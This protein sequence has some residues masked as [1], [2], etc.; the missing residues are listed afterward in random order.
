MKKKLLCVALS[1]VMTLSM[2][3]C[4]LFGVKNDA[5]MP[6]NTPS[7]ASSDDASKNDEAKA[8]EQAP[9]EEKKSFSNDGLILV[10]PYRYNMTTLYVF[11]DDGTLSDS[12]D[13]EPIS[14]QLKENENESYTYVTYCDGVFFFS[15]YKYE[16]GEN[17]KKLTAY[18][19]TTGEITDVI[20]WG[21]ENIYDV[22]VYE[23]KLTCSLS[24]SDYSS[25]TV[26]S[27]EKE[28][29]SLAFKETGTKYADI[30]DQI[31]TYNISNIERGCCIEHF[32]DKNGGLVAH[33]DDKYYLVKTDGS[34]E[35]IPHLTDNFYSLQGNADY[36][37]FTE[38]DDSY[39]TL[40][41]IC[42]DLSTGE[43]KKISDLS[44]TTMGFDNGVF[45]FAEKEDTEFGVFDLKIKSYNTAT[46]ELNTLFEK[47]SVP[48]T[49]MFEPVVTGFTVS[50]DKVFYTD[51]VEGKATIFC[52]DLADG[53]L[54]NETD[55]GLVTESFSA[56]DYGTVDYKSVSAY[57]PNCGIP[58]SQGY[59]E[60][61]SLDP[62]YSEHA[63]EINASIKE[64]A[65]SFIKSY[66]TPSESWLGQDELN[67]C[68][69]HQEYP[70]QYDMTDTDQIE[71]VGI[72][73]D[74]YLF[75]D[76][77]GYWYGGGAHGMPSRDQ[78]LYD[79][80]TG[81]ELKLTDF[82]TGTLEDYKALVAE[83]TKE[84]YESYA[85]ISE[86][87]P[88]FA[89]N[90]QEVYDTAYEYVQ[91]DMNVYFREDG[92]IYY[93]Y[94]YDMGSF[95]DGFRDIFISYKDLLGRDTL[96]E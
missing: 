72:I 83:K 11:N 56:Y 31:S 64:H 22:E 34:I 79:L 95:A 40:G 2:A 82:Y 15:G 13:L 20:Y 7:K 60:I 44:V 73:E 4:G 41:T 88:Y 67:N 81:K 14:E 28:E 52:A 39:K 71:S 43:K 19:S 90:S 55:T 6:E 89:E 10:N 35:E 80:T 78:L 1:A 42:M 16:D 66:E 70:D 92:I 17:Y 51:L 61:F 65:D 50:D 69:G 18:D 25:W 94:P 8:Q 37:C 48:A 93:F 68:E 57:C 47:K 75:V 29:D 49:E 26:K 76:K 38:Y 62:K 30:Y 27:F 54:S 46:D 77:T 45:Y 9:E 74:R 21:T 58:L 33:T 63:D 3:G 5:P 86:V 84:D 85:S 32:L 12:Y 87:T 91:L 23:G 59:A 53:K 36:C 24:S 96:S